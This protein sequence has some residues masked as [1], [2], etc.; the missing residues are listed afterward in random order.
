MERLTAEQIEA[1]RNR[2]EAATEGPWNYGFAYGIIVESKTTEVVAEEC[3]VIRYPDAEFIAEARTD[4]PALLAEVERLCAELAEA[5][6][7]A[8]TA[9]LQVRRYADALQRKEAR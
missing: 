2:A 5:N 1:I 9:R 4:I 7:Q 3:G 8:D 6:A